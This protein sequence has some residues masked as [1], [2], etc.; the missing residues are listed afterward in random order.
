MYRTVAHHADVIHL[1]PNVGRDNFLKL[2]IGDQVIK[3]W[4]VGLGEF[5][6]IDRAK[7]QGSLMNFGQ[8]LKQL[9][10]N[11][12]FSASLAVSASLLNS[13]SKTESCSCIEVVPHV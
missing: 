11:I 8:T 1:V 9:E 4:V 7:R 6:R 2:Y 10:E 12:S 5:Y 13:G 3:R